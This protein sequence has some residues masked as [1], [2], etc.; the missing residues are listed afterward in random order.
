ML[1]ALRRRAGAGVDRADVRTGRAGEPA[2]LHHRADQGLDLERASGLDVLKHGSLVGADPARA[3]DT[4]LE[5][6]AA[7]SSQ[8][9]RFETTLLAS[10]RITTMT[11][12]TD[13]HM[14]NP[15]SMAN[16]DS[17]FGSLYERYD[18]VAAFD[19]HVASPPYRTFDAATD[20]MIARRNVK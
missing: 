9:G 6:A 4:A 3:L 11:A 13:G 12:G 10:A 16:V 15:G 17:P 5:G 14:G 1:E 20:A 2:H 18:D 8:M 19:A 7:S